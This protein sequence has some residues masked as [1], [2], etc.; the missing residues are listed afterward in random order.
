M[1][2]KIL[3]TFLFFAILNSFTLFSQDLSASN[4][5]S[6]QSFEKT[7]IEK[8]NIN[9]SYENIEFSEIYSDE[10][11][12]DIYSNNDKLLPTVNKN[13]DTLEINS[14][15]KLSTPGDYCKIVVYLPKKFSLNNLYVNIGN[16]KNTKLLCINEFTIPN[17]PIKNININSQNTD[18][19]GNNFNSDIK[20][21]TVDGNILLTNI[22]SKQLYIISKNGKINIDNY[23]GE[24][25]FLKT[26]NNINADNILCDYFKV[27]TNQGSLY[28]ALKQAPLATSYI[29]STT[30]LIQL[31]VPEKNNFNIE[32]HSSKGTFSDKIINKRFTP[33]HEYSYSYNQGGAS[34]KINTT[35]GNIELDNF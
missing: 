16:S 2:K 26:D 5:I 17:I 25:I 32:V 4:F 15:M 10:I 24:Y 34:I 1:R 3:F 28:L 20:I 22:T 9:L 18:I 21:N 13:N 27:F 29:E 7:G 19:K 11:S 30:G 14:K 23:K 8:F 31:F 12:I 6:T 35:I 33:R